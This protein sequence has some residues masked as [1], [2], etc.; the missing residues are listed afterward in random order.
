MCRP[1][2]LLVVFAERVVLGDPVTPVLVGYATDGARTRRT[3][4]S[5][6]DNGSQS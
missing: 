5:K 6:N 3:M 4:G 1:A 2:L